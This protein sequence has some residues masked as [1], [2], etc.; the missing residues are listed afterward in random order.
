[1]TYIPSSR[2]LNW[3]M[4][5]IHNKQSWALPSGG[6]VVLFDH[7]NH[8]FKTFTIAQLDERQTQYFTNTYT[9]LLTLGYTESNR[10]I[11]E[12][13]SST[14]ELLKNFF[15]FSD[16]DIERSKILGI[17]KQPDDPRFGN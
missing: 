3:T 2:D 12:G 6:F 7:N 4:K 14:D 10:V 1:M 8:K 13:V 16:D 17:L 5:S 15:Q 11:C 9:N